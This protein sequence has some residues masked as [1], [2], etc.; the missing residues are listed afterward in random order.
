MANEWT[1]NGEIVADKTAQLYQGF[2][3]KLTHLATNRYYV[4]KKFFIHQVCKKPLK[5]KRFKRHSTKESDWKSYYGSNPELQEIL[6]KE[7]PGAFKREMLHLCDSKFDCAYMEALEQFERRV[8]FDPL[9]FNQVINLR[10][11]RRK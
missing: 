1:Y 5:G 6:A 4:G 2:V 9:A 8:L 10:L 7:G 3:Y 11:R